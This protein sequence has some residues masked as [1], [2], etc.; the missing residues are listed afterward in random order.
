[1]MQDIVHQMELSA[2]VCYGRMCR[3]H[4]LDVYSRASIHF[5]LNLTLK[6]H[7]KLKFGFTIL[8]YTCKL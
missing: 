1:M 4:A 2:V 6:N 8:E 7:A 3:E 5:L